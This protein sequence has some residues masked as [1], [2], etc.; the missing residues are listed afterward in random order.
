MKSLVVGS[1]PDDIDVML[2]YALD[3]DSLTVVASDG[4]A[5]IDMTRTC[6]CSG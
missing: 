1:H 4:E 2:G 5:G 3:N 6:L